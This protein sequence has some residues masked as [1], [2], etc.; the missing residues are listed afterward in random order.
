MNACLSIPTHIFKIL[1]KGHQ[2]SLGHRHNKS[3][4]SAIQSHVCTDH[5]PV[6]RVNFKMLTHSRQHT[7]S[8]KAKGNSVPMIHQILLM[9]IYY[10]YNS[11]MIFPFLFLTLLLLKRKR[12]S[13]KIGKIV[14]IFINWLIMHVLY[15]HMQLWEE[16]LFMSSLHKLISLSCKI[17][18]FQ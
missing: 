16:I 10:L 8:E 11:N 15:V 1:C 12:R 14:W 2:I 9:T 17:L 4:I 13:S 5:C 18:H 7:M 6:G 3:E